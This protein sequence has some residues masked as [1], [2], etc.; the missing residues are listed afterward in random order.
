MEARVYKNSSAGPRGMSGF[1]ARLSAIIARSSSFGIRLVRSFYM[2]AVRVRYHRD[3]CGSVQ[4]MCYIGRTL[5]C[6]SLLVRPHP[7]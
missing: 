2:W 5:L 1:A 6:H 4:C 7:S 3:V